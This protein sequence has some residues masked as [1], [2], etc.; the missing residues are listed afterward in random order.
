MTY[1]LSGGLGMKKVIVLLSLILLAAMM[2]GCAGEKESEAASESVAKAEDIS[3]ELYIGVYCLG[4][5]EYFHDH[6]IGLKAAGEMMGVK[7]QV[8]RPS[9]L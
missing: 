3:D 2:F 9:R 1:F 6:K 7:N 5:L 4:N 8:Y